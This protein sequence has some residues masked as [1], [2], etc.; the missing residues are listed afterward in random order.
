MK[1]AT[2]IGALVFAL[3][4][5]G[6]YAQ[7]LKPAELKQLTANAKTAADHMKVSK[8]YE[9]K[10]AEYEAEAKDHDALAEEYTKHPTGHDQKHPMSGLTAAHCK[11]FAEASR[12]AAAEAREIAA[13]HS[14]MAKQ[15]SK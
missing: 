1:L 7:V 8:H 14:A 5:V 4:S 13:A 12:K 15:D 11:A 6:A 10:A 3:G 9:A 2:Q